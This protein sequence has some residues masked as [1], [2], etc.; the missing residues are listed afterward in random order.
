MIEIDQH[1]AE[2]ALWAEAACTRI[3][4]AIESGDAIRGIRKDADGNLYILFEVGEG[5]EEVLAVQAILDLADLIR[6]E[7][8]R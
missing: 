7:P 3:L 4:D 1:I 2:R 8:L 6:R 5:D